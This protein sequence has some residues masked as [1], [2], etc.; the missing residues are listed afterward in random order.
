M[1]IRAINQNNRFSFGAVKIPPSQRGNKIS[2]AQ[3]L[4]ENANK[5]L[6]DTSANDSFEKASKAFDNCTEKWERGKVEATSVFFATKAIR[7]ATIEE[8]DEKATIYKE[9]EAGLKNLDEHLNK[10]TETVDKL[11]AN[12]ADLNTNLQIKSMRESE[13]IQKLKAK[14]MTNEGFNQI[15]GYED[16]KNI[17][18]KYFI[19]EIEKAEQGEEANV[20]NAVLFFGPKGNG[21]TTFSK[22]FA[23]EIGAN[24][25]QTKIALKDQ[26]E[27]CAKFYE[28]LIKKANKAKELYEETGKPSVIFIDEIDRIADNDSTIIP[29]LKDFIKDCY[30]KYHC[31]VFA[32]TNHPLNIQLPITGE[33]S[34]FPYVVSVDPPNAENKQA[35]LKYYLNDRLTNA[36]DE[37]Y[38]MLADMLKEQEEKT[39]GLYSNSFIKDKICLTSDKKDVNT[40]VNDV[41]QNIQTKEPDI[42]SEA[43]KKYNNEMD[44][45]MAD[46]VEE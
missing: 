30:K 6:E 9:K 19:S 39:G 41:N 32:A 26:S 40:S 11:K 45:I 31:I 38:K 29:E 20:P 27:L 33:E 35:I 13:A 43:V 25:I 34:L 14:Y 44:L 16:E 28:R 2:Q 15:A 24:L 21:K 36:S 3:I 42:D 37:D 4:R 5:T 46:K 1:K 23:Q 22:A 7:E 18:Y 12:L 10:V 17:L 8:R